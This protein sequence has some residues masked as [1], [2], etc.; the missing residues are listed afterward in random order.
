VGVTAKPSPRVAK[1]IST[2]P[3]RVLDTLLSAARDIL[4]NA[5][6]CE[7]LRDRSVSR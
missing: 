6:A 5:Q 7:A 4:E 3:I 2:L 1:S